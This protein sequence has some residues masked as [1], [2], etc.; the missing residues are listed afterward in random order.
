MTNTTRGPVLI[1]LFAGLMAGAGNGISIVAFP[2][3]VLQRN[4]SALDASL[5]AMAGTLPLLAS[6]L[7]AGTDVDYLGRRR[8]SM[9]ADGLSG[10]SVIAVPVIALAFGVDA[11][12]VA[13]LATLAAL[14][15]V[16][17]VSNERFREV[18]A[19][20]AVPPEQAREALAINATARLTALKAASWHSARSAC[21]R[22]CR[23]VASRGVTPWA[24]PNPG[25]SE[26]RPSPLSPSGAGGARS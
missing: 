3:L 18:L 20:A 9:I 7:I 12:N 2:W 26:P 19:S 17:F 22:S 6:T 5:V 23:R 21:W 14:G 10:L 25:T 8:V 16:G 13:V 24:G 1:I 4:R 11:V 15:Q